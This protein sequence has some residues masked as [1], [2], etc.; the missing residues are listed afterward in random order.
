MASWTFEAIG[1]SWQ[2]D[3]PDSLADETRREITALVDEFDAA[4]SRFRDDSVV[5]AMSKAAGEYEIA[6]AEELLGFYDELFE[7]TDAAVSPLIGESLAALGYDAQY[8]LKP[9]A[10]ATAVPDWSAVS[11]TGDTISLNVP[12]LIDVGAAG[13]GRLVDLVGSALAASG[14]PDATIDGSGD[15]LHHGSEP[16]R[17]GLE[18]PRDPSKALGVVTVE[19]GVALCGSATNRRAWGDELH[20]VLDGRTG[21]PTTE[22]VATWVLMPNSCMVADGL[23]TAHF[24]A[25]PKVLAARWPD[26]R[27]VR[28]HA[29]GQVLWSQN[30]P[31]ELFL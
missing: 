28:V 26:H 15:L 12:A 27:F 6:G 24:F 20:H 18:H 7:V 11:R 23:A 21:Q 25:D 2:I 14:H 13:K 4:W 8:S 19:P 10:R 17:V 1:T 29:D 9:S 3:S 31:G 30:L 5:M 16:L 22:V